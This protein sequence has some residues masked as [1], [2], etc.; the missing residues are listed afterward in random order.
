MS[1]PLVKFFVR[2]TGSIYLDS[3]FTAPWWVHKGQRRRL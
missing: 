1:N 2:L 3:Q